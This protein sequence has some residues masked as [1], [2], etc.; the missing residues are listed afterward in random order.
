MKKILFLINNLSYGGA[1]RV[2]VNL[3]NNMDKT[4]FDVTVQTLF[5]EGVNKQFLSDSVHYRSSLKKSF[6][7]NS[8]VIKML[9]PRLLYKFFVKEDYDVVV[10]YLEG[11]C[12]R[13]LS[14][15]K[16]KNT[17]KVT[18]VHIELTQPKLFKS[19]FW[20]LRSARKA[21]NKYNKIICVA[22]TVKGAFVKTLGIYP[23]TLDVLYN[24]NETDRILTLSTEPIEDIQFEN[25]VPNFCSVAKIIPTKGFDRLL[26]VH[27]RLLDEGYKHRIYLIGI[28]EQM[29]ELK[30]AA[31]EKGVADSF[32][33][34]GFKEN[35]Y[36]Y[37]KACNAYVCSSRREGFST[38]VTE[39]LVLGLPTVSTNCSGAIELLGENDDYGIV[40]DNSEEGIYEG[41]KKMLSGSDTLSH[42]K[43]LAKERGKAFKTHKTVKAVEDMLEGL[44]KN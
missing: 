9:P 37:M 6:K 25:D 22:E 15:C 44:F 19:S 5:D 42:Y 24:T 10:A 40:V 27:K 30:R 8:I 4:K 13:I 18:W 33:F 23:D 34:L 7:G 14:G 11:S 21:Y 2:L 12:T 3:A 35:P 16:D 31:A 43:E 39:A 28:G 41:M 32:I 17:K 38:A 1:E 36:K 29:E 20:T 26:N